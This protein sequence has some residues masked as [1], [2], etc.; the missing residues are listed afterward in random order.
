MPKLI[1]TT[2]PAALD[3][4]DQAKSRRS[5]HIS[6]NEGP[7]FQYNYIPKAGCILGKSPHQLKADEMN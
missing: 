6:E 3:F 2:K 5:C 7:T 4:F 1:L